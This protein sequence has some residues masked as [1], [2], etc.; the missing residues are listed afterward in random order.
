[1]ANDLG[2]IERRVKYL[3][4]QILALEDALAS[5]NHKAGQALEDSGRQF[6]DV[7]LDGNNLF[8]MQSVGV[9]P[10]SSGSALGVGTARFLQTIGTT[11]Y[12]TQPFAA[13]DVTADCANDTG[14][15]TVN[16]EYLICA[17]VDGVCTALVGDCVTASPTRAPDPP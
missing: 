12:L 7:A 9:I 14:G 8:R 5:V 17:F 4:S 2:N 15:A 10:A 11:R 1:M 13:G 6:T 3:E 16:N